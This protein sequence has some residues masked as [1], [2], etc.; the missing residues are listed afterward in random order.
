MQ[1]NAALGL[2]PVVGDDGGNFLSCDDFISDVNN[3][4]LNLTWREM[5]YI[6]FIQPS[7]SSLVD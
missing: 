4:S 5:V 1:L 7:V 2:V 3:T 6:E